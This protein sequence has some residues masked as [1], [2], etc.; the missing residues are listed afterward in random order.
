MA[1]FLHFPDGTSLDISE[2]DAYHSIGETERG[3]DGETYVVTSV[4]HGPGDGGRGIC[5]IHLSKVP[6]EKGARD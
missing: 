3:R 1:V 2:R 5:D 4:E 6:T